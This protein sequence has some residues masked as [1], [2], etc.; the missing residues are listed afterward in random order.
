MLFICVLSAVMVLTLLQ[1]MKQPHASLPNEYISANEC[2]HCSTLLTPFAN[3][4]NIIIMPY[5]LVY[6]SFRH[7]IPPEERPKLQWQVGVISGWC[8]DTNMHMGRH[9]SGGPGVRS[10]FGS[11]KPTLHCMLQLHLETSQDFLVTLAIH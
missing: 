9:V 7:A 11:Y 5:F 2:W 10:S 8:L 1:E 6:V 4:H 3:E